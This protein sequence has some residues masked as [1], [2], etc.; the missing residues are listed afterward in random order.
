M[1]SVCLLNPSGQAKRVDG[2]FIFKTTLH[3]DAPDVADA[4]AAAVAAT[5]QIAALHIDASTYRPSLLRAPS[6][7]LSE[8]AMLGAL[9]D[10]YLQFSSGGQG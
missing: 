10:K 9:M 3:H 8:R 7:V 2:T 6:G 5:P 1:Y 4:I